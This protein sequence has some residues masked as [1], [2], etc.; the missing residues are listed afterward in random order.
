[1]QSVVF[2]AENLTYFSPQDASPFVP[3]VFDAYCDEISASSC[4][5][6]RREIGSLGCVRAALNSLLRFNAAAYY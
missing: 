6:L 2:V 5:A 3:Y 1:M 4:G